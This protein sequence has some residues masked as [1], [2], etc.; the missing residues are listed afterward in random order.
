M[1]WIELEGWI[2]RAR[3]AYEEGDLHSRHVEILME[4]AL[5]ISRCIPAEN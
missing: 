1:S 4:H 5:R 3:R 2:D